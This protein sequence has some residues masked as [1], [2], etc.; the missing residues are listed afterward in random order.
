MTSIGK[1]SPE[2][3]STVCGILVTYKRPDQLRITL[4]TLGLQTRTLDALVIVDN[5]KSCTA[6]LIA[7]TFGALYVP[8]G[9]NLGPA[10]AIALGFDRALDAEEPFDWF[11]VLDDDDPPTAPDDIERL[12]DFAVQRTKRDPRCAGVGL[13]GARYNRWLGKLERIPDSDL[14]GPVLVDYFG[15]NQLP[16]Y[17]SVAIRESGGPTAA[18]F[19]GLDDVDLGM[20]LRSLRYSLWIDGC[21][22]LEKRRMHGRLGLSSLA[23]RRS[24]DASSLWRRYYSTRNTIAIAR[25]HG[26]L[27]SVVITSCRGVAASVQA[28]IA[29]RS[30]GAFRLNLV[31]VFAGIR[32]R[33]GRT[34]EPTTDKT[35]VRSS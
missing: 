28:G 7:E 23:A 34:V 3:P 29:F 20:R 12:V 30:P 15:G 19:F 2:S 22:A 5:D 27:S 33:L 21:L 1:A 13:V 14:V 31:A 11:M 26:H 16:M 8:A 24:F 6:Q 25:I 9:E 18:L 4:E 35:Q 17:R 32:L 10:G